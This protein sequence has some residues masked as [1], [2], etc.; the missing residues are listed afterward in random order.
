MISSH[1]LKNLIEEGSELPSDA[2]FNQTTPSSLAIIKK[3]S[4][5]YNDNSQ[6]NSIMDNIVNKKTFKGLSTMRGKSN[7]DRDLP[8]IHEVNRKAS[9]KLEATKL[10]K[11][12]PSKYSYEISEL[13]V[14]SYSVS[15]S[16]LQGGSLDDE[17]TS[18]AMKASINNKLSINKRLG[19]NKP[20]THADE[21]ADN[22]PIY[23]SITSLRDEESF[24]AKDLIDA[25]E[26]GLGDN[27]EGSK[28]DENN[29]NNADSLKMNGETFFSKI[30]SSVRKETL[31]DYEER[32]RDHQA[33]IKKALF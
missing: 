20:E 10:E 4:D 25:D 8:L 6:A 2:V 11:I 30:R 15:S 16:Y 33:S 9:D 27:L 13:A 14:S 3:N 19:K 12:E 22:A 28:E 29:I 23:F 7:S 21:E 24:N 5:L 31:D 1:F 32:D 26:P 18:H 17:G